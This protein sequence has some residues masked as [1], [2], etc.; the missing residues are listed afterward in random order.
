[1]LDLVRPIEAQ[2][3]AN[4]RQYLKMVILLVSDHVYFL[5]HVELVET[6]VSRTDILGHV[7]G[8]SVIAQ[9]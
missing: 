7:H 6:V 8:S 9:Q 2:F 4:Q 5:I 1:M 3:L